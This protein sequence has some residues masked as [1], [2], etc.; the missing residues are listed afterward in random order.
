VIQD[1]P[2]QALHQLIVRGL[3]AGALDRV[4]EK[5]GLS[6][7][8]IAKALGI[9]RKTLQRRRKEDKPLTAVEGDR[10]FRF[11]RIF[12][13]AK[14][15]FDSEDA[16]NRWLHKGQVGLGGD[17]PFDLLQTEAGAIEVEKY[18]GRIAHGAL[19]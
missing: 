2:A 12:A 10:I 11:A 6:D 16:A 5:L 18:L 14:R 17:V 13:L 8:D 4:K 3:P 9:S 15:I 19:S 1:R 7:E